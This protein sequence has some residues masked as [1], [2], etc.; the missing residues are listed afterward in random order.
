MPA[1]FLPD[2]MT[3][4]GHFS[5]GVS[6]VVTLIASEAAKAATNGNRVTC[7]VYIVGLKT[8]DS[9]IPPFGETHFRFCRPRP[10][11]CCSAMTTAPC[12]PGL[13]ASDSAML[14]VESADLWK[15]ICFP[16]KAVCKILANSQGNGRSVW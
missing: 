11:F 10:L 4:F 6:P 16:T 2:I 14:C 1:T 12:E 5:F 9:H 15:K 13:A 3:S 8:T 7:A